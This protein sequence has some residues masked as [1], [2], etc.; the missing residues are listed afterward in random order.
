MDE[1]V[2]QIRKLLMEVSPDPRFSRAVSNCKADAPLA[3]NV[4][5]TSVIWLGA[6]VALENHFKIRLQKSHLGGLGEN[7]SLNSVADMVKNIIA[8]QKGGP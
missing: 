5:F 8:E 4:N 3:E 6:I 7:F 2:E 1:L